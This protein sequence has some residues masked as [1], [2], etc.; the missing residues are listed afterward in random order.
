MAHSDMSPNIKSGN[1]CGHVPRCLK[2]KLSRFFTEGK[3]SALAIR[4]LDFVQLA[5]F[6]MI[7]LP[8]IELFSVQPDNTV[9]LHFAFPVSTFCFLLHGRPIGPLRVLL[10]RLSAC[11]SRGA[12]KEK[13]E[14]A[15]DIDYKIQMRVDVLLFS[16]MNWSEFRRR[17]FSPPQERQHRSRSSIQGPKPR[18]LGIE[19]SPAVFISF[20]S[21]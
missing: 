18:P 21:R 19:S 6:F 10:V 11:L 9:I 16:D 17:S 1:S 20:G 7:L 8:P 14:C 5:G 15:A 13:Q 4:L 12:R 3:F 2:I